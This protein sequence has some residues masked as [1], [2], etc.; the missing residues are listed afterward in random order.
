LD[1]YVNWPN[2]QPS[3]EKWNFSA[4]D[5]YVS[6]AEKHDVELMLPLLFS[7]DW[8]TSR[9]KEKSIVGLG[10]AAP[11]INLDDWKEYVRT[12]A[13]RYRGRIHD[14]EIWNEPSTQAFFSG[15]PQELVTMTREAGR[16]LKGVDSNNRVISP[17][18]AE[19]GTGW[20]DKFLAAGGGK[21][22]DVLGYHFYVD[23]Q[24]PEAM[25]PVFRQVRDLA[26]KY[27]LQDLPLWDTETGWQIMNHHSEVKPV[28]T[29]GGYSIVLTDDEAAAYV[30]RSYVIAWA[31]GISR[32]Y[33]YAWDNGKMG[34]TEADG[35]TLKP[36]ATAYGEIE[37]WLVGARMV[38]CDHYGATWNCRLQRNG[39]Y[40][41]WVVWN[42]HGNDEFGIQPSWGVKRARDLAGGSQNLTGAKA[43]QI[44]PKPILLENQDR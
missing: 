39:G 22:V 38:A 3:R 33:W 37:K 32:F 29:T 36:P 9:P 10:N 41:G 43:I 21:Y 26:K 27:G 20:L 19:G 25:I 35:A 11:P 18:A 8:A 42:T 23:R 31:Y 24:E 5:T 6:L 28:G 17:S 1:A 4:L 7:P 30:A 14:Y 12:V 16:V 44:G 2:V 13:S 40:S 34:L 15:T